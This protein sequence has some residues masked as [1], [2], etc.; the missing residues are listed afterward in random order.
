MRRKKS[1]FR[2]KRNLAEYTFAYQ[3]KS[4]GIEHKISDFGRKRKSSTPRI[5]QVELIFGPR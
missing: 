2:V 4:A 1:E 3:Q 5:P